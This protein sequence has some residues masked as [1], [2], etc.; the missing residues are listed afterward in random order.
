MQLSQLKCAVCRSG[1][2]TVS[3]EDQLVL[4]QEI[5]A[6]EPII[7]AGMHILATL[8]IYNSRI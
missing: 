8:S 4:M 1:T 5:P 7:V 3:H 2:P 6:W